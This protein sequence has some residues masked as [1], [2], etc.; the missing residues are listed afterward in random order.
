MVVSFA[1]LLNL[2]SAAS[3]EDKDSLWGFIRRYAPAAS[4]ESHPDLDQAAGFA[5]RYYQDFVKPLKVYRA[6]D[7]KE[8]AAMQ[9]LAAELRS[10]AGAVEDESV[11]NMVLSVGKNHGFEPLRDWF[12]ALYEVLLGQ[13]QGPRIGSFIALYG[14]TETADLID[15]ALRG[16]DLA[17]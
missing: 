5:L 1:M 15:R 12:K 13:S 4:P 17:G 11:Q 7:E 2:A 16:E 9:D 3:A 6:A 8:T 14:I 10:F